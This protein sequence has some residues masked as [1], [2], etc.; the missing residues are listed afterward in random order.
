MGTARRIF[1][2]DDA[3]AIAHAV[4]DPAIDELRS[5]GAGQERR[6]R[7]QGL[8]KMAASIV[9]AYGD[10]LRSKPHA[11]VRQIVQG[12]FLIRELQHGAPAIILGLLTAR[13][14]GVDASSSAGTAA[15]PELTSR[16][17]GGS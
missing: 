8:S 14:R 15:N 4:R 16:R 11:P 10:Y 6:I 7:D 3:A 5:L 17:R 12:N 9:N 13:T 2:L 1:N